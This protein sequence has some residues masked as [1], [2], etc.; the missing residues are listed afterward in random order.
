MGRPAKTLAAHMEDGTYRKDRHGDLNVP[1]EVPEPSGNL[2]SRA[3][4]IYDEIAQQLVELGVVSKLDAI[5]LSEA[6]SCKA[7]LEECQRLLL[8]S[9]Y[10]LDGRENPLLG[11]MN[12]LRGTLY[13]F[14][15]Q[16]GLT[17]RS[18]T[19]L[20]VKKPAAVDPLDMEI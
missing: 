12:R 4:E 16:L 1:V 11:T 19:G 3:H 13:R 6:A 20:S 2:S 10:L 15:C 17:P 14:L 5:A 18:R 8:G 7:E 9:Q